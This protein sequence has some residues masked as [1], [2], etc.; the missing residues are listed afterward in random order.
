MINKFNNVTTKKLYNN[1][2]KYQNNLKKTINQT[3]KLIKV[4]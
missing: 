1:T 3:N 2:S 4:Y